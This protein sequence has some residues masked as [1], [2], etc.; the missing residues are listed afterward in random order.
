MNRI[1]VYKEKY[2][3]A[4]KLANIY[5]AN[6]PW[7]V[8]MEYRAYKKKGVEHYEEFILIIWDSGCISTAN[9]NGNSLTATARNMARM[10]DGGVYENEE[11]Y[12]DIMSSN[13]WERVA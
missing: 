13:E 1:D 5:M 12:K 2:Y 4:R 3:F 9:N 10:L 8:L 11:F 6:F 7:I